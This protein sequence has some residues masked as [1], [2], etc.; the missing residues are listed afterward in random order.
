MKYGMRIP[1]GV[2]II[3]F[4]L[5]IFIFCGCSSYLY[6]AS[7][8]DKPPLRPSEK[9]NRTIWIERV[10]IE[11]FSD[12]DIYIK[13]AEEGMSLRIADYLRKHYRFNNIRLLPGKP[14]NDD[15][16]FKFEFIEYKTKIATTP[17]GLLFTIL[18]LTIYNWLGGTVQKEIINYKARLIVYERNKKIVYKSDYGISTSYPMNFYTRVYRTGDVKA[19]IVSNLVS[20]YISNI[21]KTEK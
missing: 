1:A 17:Q 20:D 14:H 18:T 2:L 16:I 8:S 21:K 9:I 3:I 11:G 19:Q 4:A 12:D 15:M 13:M 5:L 10:K 7:L 6:N